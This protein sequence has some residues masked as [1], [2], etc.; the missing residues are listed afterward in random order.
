MT[1]LPPRR[2]SSAIGRGGD[3]VCTRSRPLRTLMSSTYLVPIW[4]D[5]M[6]RWILILSAASFSLSGCTTWE[7]LC[8]FGTGVN[9]TFDVCAEDDEQAIAA[10]QAEH[11]D[12]DCDCTDSETT[13]YVL[14]QAGTPH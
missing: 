10:I 12:A 4:E 11:G 1:E 7:C 6:S 5:T 2:A 8:N 3:F 14:T 13:C 9:L